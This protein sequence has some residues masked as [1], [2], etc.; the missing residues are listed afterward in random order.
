MIVR[1]IALKQTLEHTWMTPECSDARIHGRFGWKDS[2]LTL[3]DFVSN[4]VSIL[5]GWAAD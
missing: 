1:F 2:P 3:L 4:L 5:P